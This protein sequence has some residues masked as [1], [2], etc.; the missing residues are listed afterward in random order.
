MTSSPQKLTVNK[1]AR[2]KTA[3]TE[4]QYFKFHNELLNKATNEKKKISSL[5]CCSQT[6]LALFNYSIHYYILLFLYPI[7]RRNNTQL[8]SNKI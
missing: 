6:D 8:N 7:N 2:T 3:A 4:F 1:S 5:D